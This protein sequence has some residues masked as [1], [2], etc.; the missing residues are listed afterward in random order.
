M[1]SNSFKTYQTK[2]PKPDSWVPKSLYLAT[3]YLI[4]AMNWYTFVPLEKHTKY[5]PYQSLQTIAK[6]HFEKHGLSCRH[7]FHPPLWTT[8]KLQ[9]QT[10]AP[11]AITPEKKPVTKAQLGCFEPTI[12]TSS[13][14][15]Q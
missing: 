13:Y 11:A 15:Y 4:Q 7:I 10:G 14:L 1:H 2:N 5:L 6:S 9:A 3:A 12:Y 8:G